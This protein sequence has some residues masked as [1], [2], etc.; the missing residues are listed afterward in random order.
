MSWGALA[1]A[2]YVRMMGI[3]HEHIQSWMDKAQQ[4]LEARGLG[5]RREAILGI[6]DLFAEADAAYPIDDVDAQTAVLA[7]AIATGTRFEFQNGKY[8]N[9]WIRHFIGAVEGDFSVDLAEKLTPGERFAYL[10]A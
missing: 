3:Y 9:G 8:A 4:D 2:S 7:L 10:A 6:G 5:E 1:V